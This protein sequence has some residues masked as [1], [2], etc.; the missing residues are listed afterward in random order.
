MRIKI[1]SIITFILIELLTGCYTTNQVKLET[2]IP[3]NKK[4]MIHTKTGQAI[5]LSKI[6]VTEDSLFGID[7]NNNYFK[8]SLSNITFAEEKKMTSVGKIWHIGLI[9]TFFVSIAALIVYYIS[10]KGL[11]GMN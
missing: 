10:A 11:E 6:K 1:F 2:N 7:E 3:F 4:I 9:T 5:Y 8:E